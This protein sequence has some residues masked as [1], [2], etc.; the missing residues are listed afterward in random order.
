M[1]LT[2][3]REY[4]DKH[5]DG[6]TAMAAPRR[7]TRSRLTCSLG[8]VLSALR[9]SETNKHTSTLGDRGPRSPRPY[10]LQWWGWTAVTRPW[11]LQTWIEM[12]KY[13]AGTNAMHAV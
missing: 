2:L 3:V 9:G 7:R 11:A 8:L 10:T 5:D 13:G 4:I 12:A 1:P 6:A